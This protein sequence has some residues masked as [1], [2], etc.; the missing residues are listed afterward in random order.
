[1]DE[2]I[3][4]VS[5]GDSQNPVAVVWTPVLISAA[6]WPVA[7]ASRVMQIVLLKALSIALAAAGVNRQS[8]GLSSLV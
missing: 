2:C 5:E 6:I 3:G 7:N 8:S 4:F 1:M